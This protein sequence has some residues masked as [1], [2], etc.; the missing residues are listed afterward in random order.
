MRITCA[1]EEAVTTQCPPLRCVRPPGL[2]LFLSAGRYY[3]AACRGSQYA[4]EALGQNGGGKSASGGRRHRPQRAILSWH[5]SSSSTRR[6]SPTHPHP[7][8]R[9]F[10]VSLGFLPL[11]NAAASCRSRADVHRRPQ[12]ACVSAALALDSRHQLLLA[13]VLFVVF[14]F[15]QPKRRRDT[16]NRSSSRSERFGHG[17]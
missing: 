2:L 17:V 3:G 4:R 15:L 8:P 14:L 12:A 9:R 6:S 10:I 16:F 7:S 5:S 1:V 13:C 11:R